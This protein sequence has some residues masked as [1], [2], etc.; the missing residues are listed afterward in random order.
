MKTETANIDATKPAANTAEQTP[1]GSPA[2][3]AK[4]AALLA[5]PFAL[6]FTVLI[7]FGFDLSLLWALPIYAGVGSVLIAL[8]L[9][10]SLLAEKH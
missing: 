1:V 10:G 4:G 2:L 9:I 7:V 5:L 3:S 6:V 8:F